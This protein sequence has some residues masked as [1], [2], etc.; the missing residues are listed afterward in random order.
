[1]MTDATHKLNLPEHVNAFDLRVQLQKNG[2]GLLAEYAWKSQ[3]PSYDNGYI[4]RQGYV[5][6]LSASYS[7]RGSSIL[8]QAKRSDNMSFRSERSVTGT[9]SFINLTSFFIQV[10]TR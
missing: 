4:Y 5:A 7:K 10:G 3:D 6:M 2:L 8:V 1:M 9:S